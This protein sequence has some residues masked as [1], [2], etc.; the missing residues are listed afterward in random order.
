MLKWLKF[1]RRSKKL[2][3]LKQKRSSRNTHSPGKYSVQFIGM[4]PAIAAAIR[5]ENDRE[6]LEHKKKMENR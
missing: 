3:A 1:G 6:I 2:Q 5:A 4:S